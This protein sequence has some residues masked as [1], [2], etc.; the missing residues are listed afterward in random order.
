VGKVGWGA[1]DQFPSVYISLYS[2][3]NIYM[4]LPHPSMHP[5]I[6]PSF[7]VKHFFYLAEVGVADALVD[8]LPADVAVEVAARGAH[9]LNE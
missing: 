7:I 5:S 8:L 3:Y 1:R 2:I 4:Y 6:H 9:D